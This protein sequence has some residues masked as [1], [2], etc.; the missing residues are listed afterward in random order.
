[1]GN[2]EVVSSKYIVLAVGGRPTYPSDVPGA[3]EH[4]IS[5]DDIFWLRKRPGKTLVVGA[6]Y[7]ALE[8]AG[9]LHGLGVDVTVMVRSIFLR[10][11]DQQMANKVGDYMSQHGMKF[12]RNAVPTKITVNS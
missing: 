9:Y 8:C 1:M 4:S 6:S 5:S 11:F 7:I 2:K 12:I 10:G 3:Y